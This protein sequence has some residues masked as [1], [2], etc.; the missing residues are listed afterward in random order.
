MVM[1]P[2]SLP[3]R[4]GSILPVLEPRWTIPMHRMLIIPFLTLFAL[5]ACAEDPDQAAIDALVKR[6]LE[7]MV[8]IEGGSFMM[9][10]VGGPFVDRYGKPGNARRWT[11]SDDDDFVHKVTL[12]GFYM[13]R[14][15]VT[16]QEF[17]LY[18]KAKGLSKIKEK[19]LGEVFRAPE[20]SVSGSTWYQA[21]GFCKW[22]GEVT[23]LPFDLPTE[24]QWEYAAR[25]RGKRVLWATNDNTFRWGE[26]IGGGQEGYYPYPPGSWPPNPLGLYDMQG[27]VS[28]W[29]KDWYSWYDWDGQAPDTEFIN[30]AGPPK[31]VGKVWRGG[32]IV[33]PWRIPTVIRGKRKPDMGGDYQGIR[34]VINTDQPLPVQPRPVTGQPDPVGRVDPDAPR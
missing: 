12:D 10:D 26:N 27:N 4:G 33:S 22:L 23:G 24:A 11:A 3:A 21:S 5:T 1:G 14:Y 7:N 2:L 19:Y 16:Y 28:E 31:G 13:S 25:A 6:S 20:L 8:F 34:C 29:V 32:A 9:G 30:P 17:D 18:T 15:E